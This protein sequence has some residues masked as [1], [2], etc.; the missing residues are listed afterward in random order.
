MFIAVHTFLW[1]VGLSWTFK[2]MNRVCCRLDHITNLY[3]KPIDQLIDLFTII[4]KYNSG[5][6]FVKKQSKKADKNGKTK[7][8]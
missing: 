3:I 7:R 5:Y 4:P 1:N 2:L 6:N 8:K